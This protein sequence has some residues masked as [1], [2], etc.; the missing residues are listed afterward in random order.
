[1]SNHAVSAQASLADGASSTREP[2]AVAVDEEGAGA[3][4]WGR[5]GVLLATLAVL[6]S[7]FAPPIAG[8]TRQP[9]AVIGVLVAFIALAVTGG[10]DRLVLGLATPLL[11]VLSAGYTGP[12]AFKAYSSSTFLLGLGTFIFAGVLT[13]LA[14]G[15]RIALG[16]CSLVRSPKITRVILGLAGAD[17]VVGSI[18]PAISEVALFLPVV[19]AINALIGKRGDTPETRRMQAALLYMDPGLVP[20]F[21]GPLILTSHFPNMMLVG[22][23][24]SH[25]H[26]HIGFAE[27]FWLNL[28]LWGLLPILYFYVRATFRLRGLTV[29]GVEQ[30]L[31]ALR[32]ELGPISRQEIWAASCLLLGVALWTTEGRLHRLPPE[33]VALIVVVLLFLPWGKLRFGQ[34]GPFMQWETLFMLGGAMALGDA[35]SSSGAVQWMTGLFTP[36]LARLNVP[37]IPLLALV[38]FGLHVARAGLTSNVAMGAAF[39]PVTASLAKSLGFAVLPF[40]VLTVNSLSFAF[41]LPMSATAFLISWGASRTS[42]WQAIKFCWPLHLISNAYIVVVQSLWFSA[43][44]HPL[45]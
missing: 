33:I 27:W 38:V 16:I 14:L 34:V 24:A 40:T 2:L 1:M 11:L 30:A 3:R 21:T 17:V 6:V 23:L 26:I 42:A 44:G 39:I 29:P 20:I 32:K 10:V 12:D 13:S 31:P 45:R 9:Q 22:Y 18:L 7:R 19:T 43:I 5:L 41:L 8:L 37:T 35:L 25:E 15:R 4:G 36:A 28:P